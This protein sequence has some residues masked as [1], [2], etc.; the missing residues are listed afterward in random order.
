M[1]VFFAYILKHSDRNDL[2]FSVILKT[3]RSVTEEKQAGVTTLR[4]T[5]LALLL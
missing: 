3:F 4:T 2:I 1:K 5:T